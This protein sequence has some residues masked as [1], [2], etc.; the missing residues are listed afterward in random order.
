MEAVG[1]LANVIAIVDLSAK[2]GVICGEYIIKARNAKEDIRKLKEESDALARIISQVQDLLGLKSTDQSH[3]RQLNA[4]ET[5]RHDVKQCEK[6]LHELTERLAPGKSPSRVR[7]IGKSLKWP[8]TSTEVSQNVGSLRHWRDC[9]LAALQVDHMHLALQREDMEDIKSL[10]SAP[11]AA[12]DSY[13]NDSA[14]F[15]HPDTRKELLRDILEWADDPDG[16]CIFWLRGPAG[17]GKSTISKTVAQMFADRGQLA[18]SFFFNRT[19]EGRNTA[20]P[21]VTTVARQIAGRVR[22]LKSP[23]LRAINEDQDLPDRSLELQFSKL[24]LEPL[25]SIELSGVTFPTLIMVV[26]ALDECGFE[27]RSVVDESLDNSRQIVQ[28]LSRLATSCGV[29][30]R[31][32]LTSRPEVPIRLGFLEDMPA[33]SHQDVALH[34]IPQPVI[35][36]DIRAFVG[37]ELEIIRVSHAITQDWPGEDV[38]TQL[39][40]ASV[41]L[42]IYASTI[43]KFINDKRRRFRPQSQLDKVLRH[44][45]GFRTGIEVTYKP[46]M[47]QLLEDLDDFERQEL[48]AQ[49]R[50]VVGA[51]ILLADPLPIISL[52]VLLGVNNDE[53]RYI[54]NSLHSVLEVPED[55]QPERSIRLFHLSF[56]EYLLQSHPG[57][58]KSFWIDEKPKHNELFDCCLQVMIGRSGFGL[59]NDICRLDDPGVLRNEIPR[60]KI[61]Q[62]IPRS[63]EYACRYWVTHLR[64]SG[65]RIQVEDAVKVHD[66][67]AQ[68][69]LYWLE[70]MSWL[71][72]LHQTVGDLIVLEGMCSGLEVSS[73]SDALPFLKENEYAINLAPCQVYVSALLFAPRSSLVRQKFRREIPNW[74]VKM[75]EVAEDWDST[76]RTLHQYNS[77]VKDV[78]WSHDGQYIATITSDKEVDVWN[79]TSGVLLGR[80]TEFGRINCITF[81]NRGMLIIGLV[82]G[83]ILLWDWVSRLKTTFPVSYGEVIYVSAATTGKVLYAL[84]DGDVYLMSETF[85]VI[86]TWHTVW[87]HSTIS[88]DGPDWELDFARLRWVHFPRNGEIIAII[89]DTESNSICVYDTESGTLI[90]S[91]AAPKGQIFFEVTVSDEGILLATVGSGFFETIDDFDYWFKGVKGALFWDLNETN[92][93]SWHSSPRFISSVRCRKPTISQHGL[94]ACTGKGHLGIWEVLKDPQELAHTLE[95]GTCV[96]FSPNGQYLAVAKFNTVKIISIINLGFVKDAPRCTIDNDDDLDVN[97]QSLSPDGLRLAVVSTRGKLTLWHMGDNKE[98]RP[99]TSIIDTPWNTPSNE[100]YGSAIAWSSD[101]TFLAVCV[102]AAFVVYECSACHL[103]ILRAVSL[104]Y[105]TCWDGASSNFMFSPCGSYIAMTDGNK[106][107]IS[108]WSFPACTSLWSQAFRDPDDDCFGVTVVFSPDGAQLAIS[109]GCNARLMDS[110]TGA[111][112]WIRNFASLNVKFIRSLAFN[113]SGALMAVKVSL[114]KP[115]NLENDSRTLV[116]PDQMGFDKIS[117][118]EEELDIFYK[119]ESRTRLFVL[120]VSDRANVTIMKRGPYFEEVRY[121]GKMDFTL[122]DDFVITEDAWFSNIDGASEESNPQIVQHRPCNVRIVKHGHGGYWVTKFD[123]RLIHCPSSMAESIPPLNWEL[124]PHRLYGYDSSRSTPFMIELACTQC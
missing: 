103:A 109:Q 84:K 27:H 108:L 111:V 51:I 14:R 36:H 114:N 4:S 54:L 21:F 33:G 82:S 19:R 78:A 112:I 97:S 20:K 58:D 50:K 22:T 124:F 107:H 116:K 34:E 100:G 55:D 73:Q 88:A 96:A 16:R 68:Y 113:S 15:C 53:I 13:D 86:H 61:C 74:I 90:H 28:I 52:G 29:K 80:N 42:F 47:D 77:S 11:G 39:V 83:G 102:S 32:F 10:P 8:L 98:M 75:P 59:R 40:E 71:G 7:M 2:L 6:M 35:E 49:F 65:S 99:E 70:A 9:F 62:Q 93:S 64:E 115:L 117:A 41:P 95:Y 18:A 37:T 63:L 44:N 12:F 46:I 67:L 81:T 3:G 122:E 76:A 123:R 25:N 101:G 31:V 17:T 57:G 94:L 85:D 120:D 87:R 72:L 110:N 106:H 119:D 121:F 45:Y 23:I 43:C 104:K 105:E 48:L 92:G 118:S 89:P 69:L 30:A 1:V 66:F 56:R 5:F 60:E 26:G 38:V 91:L 24:I 79:A